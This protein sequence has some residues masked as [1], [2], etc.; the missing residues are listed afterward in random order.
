MNRRL[1]WADYRTTEY[2]QIDPMRTIAILPTAAVEQHGPHLPVG[3][4]TMIAQGMLDQLRATCPDDLDIRILPI[5]SIGKSNEH[6]HAP[7]TLTLPAETALAAWLDI[8]LSVARAGVRKIVIVNSHGGNLDLISILSRELRVRAA[9]LAVKC[10]WGSFGHPASMYSD[11]ELAFGIHGGDVETS[12]MRAFRPDTVD[13]ERAA[14][15]RSTAQGA[16]IPPIGPISYGWVASDLNPAG[17]V[18]NAAAATAEKGQATCAHQV[19]GLV[20][21]LKQVAGHSLDGL[22]ATQ[23]RL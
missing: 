22:E 4:D 19:A 17:T 1:D 7:G 14:D 11:H 13:M 8:G 5:Q 3:T 2:A 9:M 20:R 15:F 21:L 10:Q 16:A 23:P 12:L 6:I 18:G